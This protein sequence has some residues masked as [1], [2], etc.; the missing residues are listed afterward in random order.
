MLLKSAAR[1]F[2]LI[3]P[4][5]FSLI[6]LLLTL[7]TIRRVPEFYRGDADRPAQG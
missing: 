5:G 6:F 3:G 7:E 2:F 1:A 4:L